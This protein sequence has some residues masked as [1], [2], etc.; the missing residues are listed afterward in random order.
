[1]ATRVVAASVDEYI[2]AFPSACRR[3]LMAIRRVVRRAV[4]DVEE[5][6]SYGIV[7]FER[8]GKYIFYM[9]GWD[10]HVGLYPVHGALAAAFRA[11][12]RPYLTG[13]AT[14]RFP[15]ADGMPLDLVARLVASRLEELPPAPGRRA[16]AAAKQA[17]ADHSRSAGGTALRRTVGSTGGRTQAGRTRAGARGRTS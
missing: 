9:A 1:M 10:E 11:E 2:A 17:Q 7:R 8:G 16:R 4:P 15:L 14:L 6:I 13:K 12:L 3:A 5:R